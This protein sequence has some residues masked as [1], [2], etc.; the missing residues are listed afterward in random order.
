MAIILPYG[1]AICYSGYRQGQSP[2]TEIPTKEQIA[3]DLNIL[4]KDGYQYIRMYDPNLHARR[5]LEIIREKQLP[6]KC[7]IGIDSDPEVNNP[8][9]PFNDGREYSPEELRN[10]IARNDAEID[11]LIQLAEEFDEEIVALSVGNENTPEWTA[12]MVPAKRLLS[13]AE[14]LKKATN[15]PITFCEIVPAWEKLQ[16]L[17]NYLDI[18]SIHSYPL[19]DGLTIDVALKTNQEHLQR[20]KN[21]FPN[22]QVIFTEMGWTTMTNSKMKPGQ[23]CVE[24]QKRY[25]AEI[26]EWM[27][28][29]HIIGFIFEAFDEPWKGNT[30]ADSEC[31]WGLYYLDRTHK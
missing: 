18:I 3:E 14:R 17:G 16:E 23:A 5:V 15:K 10:N 19:H 29:E 21:I 12:H 20:V 8:N 1:K 9:C 7:M 11:A 27:E 26:S 28:R 22:K 31:N 13:H 24:N 25:I 2:K 6:L 4:V 30:P